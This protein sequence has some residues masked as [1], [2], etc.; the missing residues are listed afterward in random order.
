M[1]LQG[2]N[3]IA[4]AIEPVPDHLEL[5]LELENYHALTPVE[6]MPVS[7]KMPVV[8]TM[9]RATHSSTGVKYTLRRIHGF[10][11]QSTKCMSII[12]SWKK[13]SHSNIVQLREVFT[14][15]ACGDNCEQWTGIARERSFTLILSFLPYCSSDFSLRLPCRISDAAVQVF[16]THLGTHE[17]RRRRW[18]WEGVHGSLWW[19]RT[20]LQPQE[21]NG[22]QHND[23]RTD[24]IGERD[25][26]ADHAD[27]GGIKGDPSGGTGMQV[28]GEEL[29][30]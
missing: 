10:R 12:D 19:R 17:R 27:Y 23:D 4:N 18:R 28:K 22:T 5:P 15:K 24:V 16:H 2:R 3:T 25:L 8:A 26:V 30:C 11:L 29:N 1:D 7:L 14:T 20:S 13:L 9:Y 21:F 6:P